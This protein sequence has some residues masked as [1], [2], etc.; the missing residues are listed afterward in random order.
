MTVDVC[1]TE[2]KHVGRLDVGLSTR[3][4]VYQQGCALR[5]LGPSG[6]LSVYFRVSEPLCKGLGV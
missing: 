3:V 6:T 1:L 5:I 2:C 4:L